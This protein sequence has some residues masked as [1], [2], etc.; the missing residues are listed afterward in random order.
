MDALRQYVLSIVC[1]VIV[2]GVAQNLLR[3][4][5]VASLVKV[6]CGMV[7][8]VVVLLPIVRED[9]FHWDLAFEHLN[10]ERLFAVSEGENIA[11]DL[12]KQHIKEQ[13]EAYILSKA[14][15]LGANIIVSVD[16]AEEHPN[17]PESVTIQGEISPYAK[18]RIAA[19]VAGDLGISEDKQTWIS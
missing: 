18:Q 3:D 14:S 9:V 8:S 12:R 17:A 11:E 19:N 6:V 1:V 4:S 13:T 5:T 15:D 2:C 10:S 7:I 16:L